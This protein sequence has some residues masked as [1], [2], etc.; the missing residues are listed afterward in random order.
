MDGG[1]TRYLGEPLQLSWEG[2]LHSSWRI[3]CFV[4][5]FFSFVLHPI[6]PFSALPSALNLTVDSEAIPLPGPE[7]QNSKVIIF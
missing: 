4:L 1:E 6:S 2:L 3:S 5:F 7:L